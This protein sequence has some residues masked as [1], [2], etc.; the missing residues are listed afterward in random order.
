MNLQAKT[1]TSIQYNMFKEEDISEERF[2]ILKR[3][4]FLFTKEEIVN[5]F[6]GNFEDVC[7]Y[8]SVTYYR[9]ISFNNN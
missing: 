9:S 4:F 7:S 3:N 6:I 1:S 8:N 5:K 2:K